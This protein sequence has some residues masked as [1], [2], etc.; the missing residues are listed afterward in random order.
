MPSPFLQRPSQYFRSTTFTSLPRGG[1]CG[2]PAPPS[3]VRFVWVRPGALGIVLCHLLLCEWQWTGIPKSPHPLP[4]CIPLL[5]RQFA[6]GTEPAIVMARMDAKTGSVTITHEEGRFGQDG[7]RKELYTYTMV[8]E[9]VKIPSSVHKVC[10]GCVCRVLCTEVPGATFTFTGGHFMNATGHPEMENGPSAA[11]NT[12][13][14]ARLFLR[15]FL[16][17]FTAFVPISQVPGQTVRI[18][19]SFPHGPVQP[20]QVFNYLPINSFGFNFIIQ[21]MPQSQSSV[22]R[23]VFWADDDV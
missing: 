16:R 11:C 19:L 23:P 8:E 18:S 7:Y 17:L 15:C 2:P 5:V 22:P 12:W 21:V 20:Q 13:A 1:C 9:E 6:I 14:C 10:G 4:L 3:S